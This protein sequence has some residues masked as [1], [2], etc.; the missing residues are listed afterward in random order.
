MSSKL[1][2]TSSLL[3]A[4]SVFSSF[5]SS[6]EQIIDWEL[7]SGLDYKTGRASAQLKAYNGK[8]VK[9]PGFMIPLD[10][11]ESRDVTEFLLAP[12]YPGCIH[13]P[14]PTPNQTIHVKM[15]KGKKA[16]MSWGPIWATGTLKLIEEKKSGYG[17]ASFELSGLGIEEYDILKSNDPMV[18]LAIMG[19]QA[20]VPTPRKNSAPEAAPQ[21]GPQPAGP[22]ESPKAK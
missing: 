7:L 13:V 11:S 8:K 12:S 17:E 16:K 3:V 1:R 20:P 5:A 14:P 19:P 9:I 10:F 21:Q 4:F 18:N 22:K 2:L 15:S 6:K